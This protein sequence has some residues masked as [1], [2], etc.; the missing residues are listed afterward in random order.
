MMSC[1]FF[2]SCLCQPYFPLL[3]A[4]H[5]FFLCFPLLFFYIFSIAVAARIVRVAKLIWMTVGR[6][7]AVRK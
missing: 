5:R 3:S 2:Q 1:L 4:F 7:E 6:I